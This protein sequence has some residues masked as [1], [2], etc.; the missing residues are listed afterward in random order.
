M[1]LYSSA[2]EFPDL[3]WA[4]KKVP[5][6][7][8]I[9]YEDAMD[10]EERRINCAPDSGGSREDEGDYLQTMRD[11]DVAIT[12]TGIFSGIMPDNFPKNR[13]HSLTRPRSISP[14]FPA[15]EKQAAGLDDVKKN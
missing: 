14:Y 9:S 12:M 2:P 8:I 3:S 6:N 7:L 5:I 15:S 1:D 13:S 11:A 10:F 4:Q